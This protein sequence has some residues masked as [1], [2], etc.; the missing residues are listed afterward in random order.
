MI[1]KRLSNMDKIVLTG[2]QKSY[3][4]GL[5]QRMEPSVKV[6]K[7]GLTAAILVEVRRQLGA[8][9]LIKVRFLGGD[10]NERSLHCLKLSES[11]GSAFVGAV[12]QTALFYTPSA[13]GAKGA[14]FPEI[15]SIV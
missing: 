6:G 15:Q 7:D 10:R 9:E 5:G 1:H 11:T 12:G 2:S 3:L 8:H 13:K 14:I 4:R